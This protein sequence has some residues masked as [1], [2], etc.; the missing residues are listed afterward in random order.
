MLIKTTL[1]GPMNV[2][3]FGTSADPPTIGHQAVLS[4]LSEHFD[5]CAVW[6]SDNPF[7][8]HHA[9][10]AHRI[11]MMQL[12]IEAIAKQNLQLHP[13]I[14]NPR[15]LITVQLA[16]QIWTEAEFTLVI[17]ADLV[18]QLPSWYHATALLQQVKVLVI[19]RSGYVLP[20]IHLEAL[21][22]L[23]AIVAIADLSVPTVS[24]SAYR[25]N[26]DH[27]GIIPSVAAY[28]RRERLYAWQE[29][30]TTTHW[31]TSK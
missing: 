28:I 17:G 24:S 31:Q 16:R 6:V 5:L 19:P 14:S 29:L 26:S 23:G 20:A 8:S 3:L 22:S 9:A 21:Q 2:A 4:W 11:A 10:I 15:S 1:D 7:K 25:N 27:S 30:N 18:E 12:M 13:E